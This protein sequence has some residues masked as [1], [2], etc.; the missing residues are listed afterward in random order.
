MLDAKAIG[1]KLKQL[2]TGNSLSQD[3]LSE[4][5]YVSR[6]AIS[7][8]ELGLALP[9]V[10]NLIELMKLYRVSLEELLCMNDEVHIN[11]DNIFEGHDRGFIIRSIISGRISVQLDK[12]FYQMSDEERLLLLKAIKEN[13]LIADKRRLWVKLTPEEQKYLGNGGMRYYEQ[14]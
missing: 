8:W 11:K 10:D 7:R 12:V 1:N 4:F 5:L 14:Y 2:R 13:R 3:Q 9:T 6:Q